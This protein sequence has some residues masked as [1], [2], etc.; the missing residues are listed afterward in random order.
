MFCG[1]L[2]GAT[3]DR[4][5]SA[6]RVRCRATLSQGDAGCGE[7]AQPQGGIQ[8][9]CHCKLKK[10]R[11]RK[12]DIPIPARNKQLHTVPAG[13]GICA[14]ARRQASAY[15]LTRCRRCNPRTLVGFG[16][17]LRGI[18]VRCVRRMDKVRCGKPLCATVRY[19]ACQLVRS[20]PV[21][22]CLLRDLRRCPCRRVQR[23]CI[24][25]RPLC[26]PRI[27]FGEHTL[28]DAC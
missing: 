15:S 10:R 2:C 26:L 7:D 21:A 8:Y 22:M 5:A 1:V 24:F 6:C 3:A 17:R 20:T 23:R 13:C 19:N 12:R 28:L 4:K 9:T 27:P 25:V 16:K 11:A 18:H 14:A